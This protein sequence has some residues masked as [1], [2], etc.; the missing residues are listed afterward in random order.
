MGIPTDGAL[1]HELSFD[2]TRRSHSLRSRRV[3]RAGRELLGYEQVI[4][5]VTLSFEDD[6]S[7][8]RAVLVDNF[9]AG[10][11]LYIF[12]S[13]EDA[14]PDLP[15]NSGAGEKGGRLERRDVGSG[16][17]STPTPKTPWS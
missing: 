6:G 12:R 13:I 3:S 4:S 10:A 17:R 14:K 9:D 15:M 1:A 7:M 5:T 2:D 16:Q 8:D 11:D